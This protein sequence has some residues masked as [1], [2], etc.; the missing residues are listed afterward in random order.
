M[1][2]ID[3]A[4]TAR[5][6]RLVC[7]AVLGFSLASV[8]VAEPKTSAPMGTL[9]QPQIGERELMLLTDDNGKVLDVVEY[10]Y[11]GIN[12]AQLTTE[13][14]KGA[15]SLAALRLAHAGLPLTQADLANLPANAVQEELLLD[16]V[17]S[18]LAGLDSALPSLPGVYQESTE[19]ATIA[20]YQAAFEQLHAAYTSVGLDDVEA[21]VRDLDQNGLSEVL[22]DVLHSGLTPPDYVEFWETFD[23]QPFFDDLDT[24]EG[25]FDA[26]LDALMLNEQ[27][28]KQL[29]DARGFNL[30]RFL[31]RLEQ[32]QLPPAYLISDAVTY[33]AEPGAFIDWVMA[34][35]DDADVAAQG[36]LTPDSATQTPTAQQ[37]RATPG[38]SLLTWQVLGEMANIGAPIDLIA[39]MRGQGLDPHTDHQP[40]IDGGLQPKG[41][42]L[43]PNVSGRSGSWS[44]DAKTYRFSSAGRQLITD[45]ALDLDAITC[46][47]YTNLTPAPGQFARQWQLYL[48]IAKGDPEIILYPSQQANR[49]SYL[50][51]RNTGNPADVLQVSLE[52]VALAIT[53]AAQKTTPQASNWGGNHSHEVDLLVTGDGWAYLINTLPPDESGRVAPANLARLASTRIEPQCNPRPGVLPGEQGQDQGTAQTPKDQMQRPTQQGNSFVGTEPGQTQMLPATKDG[54]TDGSDQADHGPTS[55]EPEQKPFVEGKLL[56]WQQVAGQKGKLA[57]AY[58]KGR[59]FFFMHSTGFMGSNP[60]IEAYPAMVDAQGRVDA[61]GQ[62]VTV[63]SGVALTSN[64][65]AT[66]ARGCLYVAWTT[67]EGADTVAWTKW[68]CEHDLRNWFPKEGPQRIGTIPGTAR[69]VALSSYA[70]PKPPVGDPSEWLVLLYTTDQDPSHIH[71]WANSGAGWV[72]GNRYRRPWNHGEWHSLAALKVTGSEGD[73]SILVAATTSG[74]GSSANQY[75]L[76]MQTFNGSWH[77]RG[78]YVPLEWIQHNGTLAM[79]AGTVPLPSTQD[80]RMVQIFGMNTGRNPQLRHFEFPLLGK[81]ADQGCLLGPV[82]SG[83]PGYNLGQPSYPI[84]IAAVSGFR[85]KEG[86]SQQFVTVAAEMQSNRVLTATYPSDQYIDLGVANKHPVNTAFG[87]TRMRSA[88]TLLGVIEGVPPFT[89]N[90]R[91]VGEINVPVSKVE[92][93]ESNEQAITFRNSYSFDLKVGLG[94]ESIGVSAEVGYGVESIR[95]STT[96]ITVTEESFFENDEANEDG[97]YGYLLFARPSLNNYRYRWL[98]AAGHE[99]GVVNQ[100][101]VPKYTLGS[102]PYRLTS[103][104]RY[105]GLPKRWPTSEPR[106]WRQGL[107]PHEG[108]PAQERIELECGLDPATRGSGKACSFKEAKTDLIETTQTWSVELSAEVKDALKFSSSS[109]V[110]LSNA[111]ET[112][113]TRAGRAYVTTLP[114]PEPGYPNPIEKLHMM[115]YWITPDPK[116]DKKPYWVP[117][118]FRF[119]RPWLM[120]WRVGA[121][122]PDDKGNPEVEPF[123]QELETLLQRAEPE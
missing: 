25:D 52:R 34:K 44:F 112:T 18:S 54:R 71:V 90:G 93:A 72:G 87:P 97:E 17:E 30:A 26:L 65:T 62:P 119:Q 113:K 11:V 46:A 60:Q 117:D 16:Q 81:H 110:G 70:E 64:L 20:Q 29:L 12:G 80:Q 58:F 4:L 103:D 108:I 38:S 101:L 24:V 39:R 13:P 9:P 37:D 48:G 61:A 79:A 1:K 120:T 22:L 114:K 109:S 77:T 98:S 106:A 76:R 50:G 23:A 27:A 6:T 21:Q 78:C 59:Q 92:Y 111:I 83:F 2:R 89:R 53:P 74:D 40:A 56:E 85:A 55:P 14:T 82:D 86:G 94:G 69:S 123:R 88:W 19:V 116:G 91:P 100:L 57:A 73:E 42:L 99:F 10:L 28:F 41:G 36:P 67:R 45:V 51:G 121:I 115:G 63:H 33:A 49:G 105:P 47:Q 43:D 107:T 104:D 102:E 66:V 15:G 5:A 3:V 35:G 32:L 68:S 95:S 8:A 118:A 7:A 96:T 84:R 31:G 75:L 122:D